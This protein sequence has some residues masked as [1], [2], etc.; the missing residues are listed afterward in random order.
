MI[1]IRKACPRDEFLI[2]RIYHEALEAGEN[3]SIADLAC[4]LMSHEST[5]E[6]VSLVAD[7]GGDLSGHVAFSPV[8]RKDDGRPCGYILSPL[9]VRP[10]KQRK[11]VGRALIKS[12]IDESK[13]L[14]TA[15]ILV[16]G[17]PEYYAR[18]GF[19]ADVANNFIPEFELKYP[20][21]WQGIRLSD[22]RS[23]LT[24]ITIACVS[25]LNNPELW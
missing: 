21:G 23:G 7:D 20:T 10:D 15:M 3:Q 25:P 6:T 9:A 1:K 17:D 19:D 14:G 22:E 16:Y 18:F 12:G 4:R 13:R 11:G 24:P 2:R 8:F 5:P